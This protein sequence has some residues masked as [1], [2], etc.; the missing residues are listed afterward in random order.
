MSCRE[1]LLRLHDN[2]NNESISGFGFEFLISVLS[3]E[4]YV[5]S[6]LLD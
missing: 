1:A 2:N 3:S 5:V 4:F 6:L